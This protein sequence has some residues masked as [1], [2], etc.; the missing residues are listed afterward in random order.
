MST[1]NSKTSKDRQQR[2]LYVVMESKL[3]DKDQLEH[4]TSQI[5]YKLKSNFTGNSAWGDESCSGSVEGET[6][7][8]LVQY[9]WSTGPKGAWRK[10]G[11]S[12]VIKQNSEDEYEV[13]NQTAD[14][15]KS[16]DLNL[17][18]DITGVYQV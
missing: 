17:E 16:T 18:Q 11:F 9:W 1:A 13:Y 6:N 3:I 7:K 14:D 5:A 4:L 12:A 10:Y 2:R 15:N 8:V